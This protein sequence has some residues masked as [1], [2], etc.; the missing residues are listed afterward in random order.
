[1]P[2]EITSAGLLVY[3]PDDNPTLPVASIDQQNV[4]DS[5]V[6]AFLSSGSGS[7]GS[8]PTAVGSASSDG[9][10][11]TASISHSSFSSAAVYQD[12]EYVSADAY[13]YGSYNGSYDIFDN[14]LDAFGFNSPDGNGYDVN[15]ALIAQEQTS[16]ILAYNLPK[17]ISDI[18]NG[19]VSPIDQVTVYERSG[20]NIDFGVTVSLTSSVTL[21]QWVGIVGYVDYYAGYSNNDLSAPVGLTVP[22]GGGLEMNLAQLYNYLQRSQT[23][24]YNGDAT[25][26]VNNFFVNELGRGATSGDS[27][28]WSPNLYNTGSDILLRQTLAYAQE[29]ANRVSASWQNTLNRSIDGT[30]LQAVQDNLFVGGY[31]QASWLSYLAYTP[32]ASADLNAAFQNILSRPLDSTGL[33]NA[34]ANLANGT[35]TQ[36][37][38]LNIVAYSTEAASDITSLYQN[39]LGRPVDA[40]SLPNIQSYLSAG[41]TMAAEMAAVAYSPEAGIAMGNVWAGETG[42]WIDAG[43]LSYWQ[44]QFASGQTLSTLESALAYS[45]APTIVAMNSVWV[46]ETGVPIDP[47]NQSFWQQQFA[48]G[49]NI[50]GLMGALAYGYGPTITAINNV[51]ENVLGR[52]IDSASLPGTQANFASGETLQ[53]LQSGA[54]YSQ[55]AQN[56]ISALNQI[57]SGAAIDA[58]TQS[59]LQN[60]LANGAN[61]GGVAQADIASAST[62]AVLQHEIAQAEGSD[63]NVSDTIQYQQA[64]QSATAAA[65]ITW[66]SIVS[67]IGAGALSFIQTLNPISEAEAATRHP[68]LTRAQAETLLT[69][70]QIQAALAMIQDAEGGQPNETFGHVAIANQDS[71]PTGYGANTASGAY[72][73]VLKSWGDYGRFLDGSTSNSFSA[74]ADFSL[75]TQQ[76]VALEMMSYNNA[77]PDILSGNMTAAIS[78]L[79]GSNGQLWAALPGGTATRVTV[80]HAI[81]VFTA[82]GGVVSHQ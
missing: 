32:E 79:A 1:M 28:G 10:A 75:H 81:S 41:G 17:A 20:N 76:L 55:E 62:Y 47:G 33:G 3:I 21:T 74:T 57:L 38:W 66:S 82:N 40:G 18:N 71:F 36:A 27:A 12:S 22:G 67:S 61:V 31:T 80:D 48:S 14:L 73:I 2:S 60:M 43:N 46:G 39:L 51:Y 44:Q 53:G 70:P 34:Q 77:I 68:T 6:L 8:D 23:S 25:Q 42:V 15:P 50:P 78:E 35:L 45:Y 63:Y 30:T 7:S 9:V 37:G 24:L 26:A 4:T 13:S 65:P 11:A 69:N 19:R 5:Q 64:L 49:N 56:D 16:F 58:G 59:S 54:A 52:P 29:A 72:A